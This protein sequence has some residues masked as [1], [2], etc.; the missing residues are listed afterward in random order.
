MPIS[1]A[2]WSTAASV[3]DERPDWPSG[4][5]IA[6]AFGL[7][8]SVAEL[9]PVAGAWSNRVFRLVVGDEAYA[10][11]ELLDI[12]REPTWFER[13]GEA[14]RFEFAAIEAG[15]DAPDPVPNP[16]DGGWRGDVDRND[17]SG[18]AVVRLHRWIDAPPTP[19]GVASRALAAWSGATLARLHGL[20]VDVER[21]DLFPSWTTDAA[22]RW[23]AL[24]E[25]AER[26]RP[27]WL[28]LVPEA[29]RAIETISTGW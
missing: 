4:A 14:W 16:R 18:S 6:T 10:V 20:A 13:I 26:A 27:P 15:V 8:G 19:N 29:T 25:A 21:P 7:T 1:S 5:A 3:T 11:K 12:W 17:G 28:R 2:R 22:D 9:E 24:V 23:P